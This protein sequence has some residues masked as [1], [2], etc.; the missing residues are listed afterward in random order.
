M[1]GSTTKMCVRCSH[2]NS[3][4]AFAALALAMLCVPVAGCGAAGGSGG[5]AVFP[6]TGVVKLNGQPV[7]GADIVF[8]LKDGTGSSFGRTD[9]SG[10]YQLTT[11]RS[12]DGAPPGDYLVVIS[13]ADE[14]PPP[15]SANIPQD[16]P[17][18]N[19]F[20]GKAAPAKPKAKSG[21]PAKYADAKTSGLTARVLEEKNTIDFELK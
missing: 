17:N 2:Q 5:P 1:F 4:R 18:Y 7:A 8:N 10:I 6:V 3:A 9:A 21:I 12:N 13:K 19:P 11:R 20:V 15:D 14:A 16:S